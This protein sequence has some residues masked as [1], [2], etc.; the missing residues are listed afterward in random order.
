MAAMTCESTRPS[1]DA[2]YGTF[3]LEFIQSFAETI[4]DNQSCRGSNYTCKST[5]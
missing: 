5:V 4:H 1:P 2:T 3:A